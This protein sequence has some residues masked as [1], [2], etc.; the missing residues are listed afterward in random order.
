[1]TSGAPQGRW[2]DNV[3]AIWGKTGDDDSWLPLWRH[4]EDSAAVAGLVWDR[5]LPESV[6]AHIDGCLAGGS[7]DG[8]RLL[9]WLASIHDIGKATPAF[10][11]KAPAMADRLH[12]RGFDLHVPLAETS[13]APH[14][15][16]GYVIVREWLQSRFPD[17]PRPVSRARVAMA[18]VVGA[19][20]GV[21]PDE[22]ALQDL[23]H[24]RDYLGGPKWALAREEILD[25]MAARAGV[26]DRLPEWLAKPLPPTVQASIAAAVVVADW[27]ASDETRFPYRDRAQDRPSWETLRLPRPWTASAPPRDAAIHLAERFPALAGFSPTP[28]QEA[29]IEAAWSADRPPLIVLEAEMGSGKTEAGLAAA[30]VLAHRF[31]QGGVFVGLPTMATSDAMFTRVRD[32]IDQLPGNTTLS[33]FLAHGKAGLNDDYRG[34][35]DDQRFV[36]IYD[37][38]AGEPRQDR[39]VATVNAWTRGR[40]KGVL[41]PFVVGTIDQVLFGALRSRHL[42]LRHLALSG[43]VV[44]IDEVHAADTYMR[45][46]L[47]AALT[48]LGAYGTP[49]V[50][51]SA[52]LPSQQRQQLIEAYATGAGRYAGTWPRPPKQPT[53]VLSAAYPRTT[54]LDSTLREVPTQ[55]R[56]SRPRAVEVVELGDDL[57]VLIGLLRTDLADGG[58]A[59][60]VR[61]TV[62]RAQN[63]WAALRD[64]LPDTEIV[65]VH[66]RFLAVDRARRE[67]DLRERLGRGGSVA[68]GT[69]PRRLVVVG[70]QVL[71]QSLDIDVDLMVTDLAPVDLMLQRAG[72]LHRHARGVD[73]RDRPERLRQPR[74]VVTGAAWDAVPVEPDR[75][76]RRIYGDALLLRSA[77]TLRTHGNRV[78]LP[79]D[80]P[81][82]VEAAYDPSLP[83]PAG[84]E[85]QW[86]KATTQAAEKDVT[87]KSR[88]ETFRLCRPHEYEGLLARS[89]FFRKGDPEDG[90][91]GRSQVRDSEDSLEVVVVRRVDGQVCPMPGTGLGP[92]TVLPT[93]Q[94]PEPRVARALA[95][96]TVRLPAWS[97]ARNLDAA[98]AALEDMSFEGWQQDCPWLAGQLTL[99]LDEHGRARVADLDLTYDADTGLMVSISKEET[100]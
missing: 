62:A 37:E 86:A 31:G 49:V 10:A 32:W 5:W 99:V 67:A 75:G 93:V 35:D 50:L 63:T 48:W 60:V 47:T 80:I 59:S 89:G 88:A 81:R 38:E 16:L 6:K 54:V 95:G 66:S 56:P 24:R 71:E 68:D 92:D 72:R 70:T 20:H 30:E 2:S 97:T 87:A 23:G 42:A 83:A 76:S 33:M 44:V 65:L 13:K 41:A 21:L 52:T 39:A 91:G 84:W 61:N 8:R 98:I 64:A 79:D 29:A 45:E 51:M 40:R 82:L 18:V 100:A 1:M 78:A 26:M 57:D 36:G 96:C 19:H 46:Y 69:R 73:E 43:K 7:H 11:V 34:L 3:M 25:E 74:L 55:Q 90:N 4:L 28:I 17:L 77:A 53:P 58:C 94:P 12:R 9:M 15:A 22:R 85:S 27:L 14:G